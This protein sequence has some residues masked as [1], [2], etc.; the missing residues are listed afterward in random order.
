MGCCSCE[1]VS[2]GRGCRFRDSPAGSVP[3][4][5][6]HILKTRIAPIRIT[7][8]RSEQGILA[9]DTDMWIVRPATAFSSVGLISCGF[10]PAVAN[11]AVGVRLPVR[12]T[13]SSS[14]GNIG[15]R[16]FCSCRQTERDP[17]GDSVPEATI[18]QQP[19]RVRP[20]THQTPVSSHA[21][22]PYNH[23]RVANDSGTRGGSHDRMS[24]VRLVYSA[25]VK[26]ARARVRGPVA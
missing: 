9:N 21:R 1:L 10:V 12:P 14:Q 18:R 5:E 17:P 23:Q 8:R 3:R 19:Y 13:Q 26:P 6:V 25:G 11:E 22:R 24:S 20:R 2:M 4:R 15:R 16:R 7:A